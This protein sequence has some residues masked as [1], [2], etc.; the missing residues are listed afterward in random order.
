MHTVAGTGP[1]VGLTGGQ[2][3]LQCLRL[4]V[5]GITHGPPAKRHW[6]WARA[7]SQAV[8]LASCSHL[9]QHFATPASDELI[10]AIGTQD[11]VPFLAED[12]KGHPVSKPVQCTPKTSLDFPM[13]HC[14][15]GPNFD[16]LVYLP[17]TNTP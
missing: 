15:A 5:G 14:D 4:Q 13:K 8:S 2:G 11:P 12:L 17:T 9:W 1:W 3:D 7:L 16:F 10:C 6:H